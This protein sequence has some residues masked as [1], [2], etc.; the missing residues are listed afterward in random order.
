MDFLFSDKGGRAGSKRRNVASRRGKYSKPKSA[1]P[2]K[3]S[4]KSR[5]HTPKELTKAY[6]NLTREIKKIEDEREQFFLMCLDDFIWEEEMRRQE[7][8][9]MEEEMIENV[10]Y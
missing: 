7:E 9:R 10:D 2:D 4:Y 8:L 6:S 5:T 3:K 1:Y